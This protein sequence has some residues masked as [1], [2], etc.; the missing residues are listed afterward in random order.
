[1]GRWKLHF[2]HDYR[3]LA[4]ADVRDDGRPVP[5]QKASIEMALF[6]LQADPGE[7]TDVKADHPE[8]VAAIEKLADRMRADLGDSARKITGS[9]RRPPGRLAPDDKRFVVRD[10][11]QTVPVRNGFQD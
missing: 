10:G 1:M 4:G 9:G 2:P 8:V 11:R 6:D 3:T 5:Y 7:T